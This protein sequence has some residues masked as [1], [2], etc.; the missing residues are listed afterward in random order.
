MN[1]ELSPAQK[2]KSELQLERATLISWLAGIDKELQEIDD[3]RALKIKQLRLLIEEYQLTPEELGL[4]GK[5]ALSDR[6]EKMIV[7]EN[8]NKAR[9]SRE[10]GQA[11][12]LSR[13]GG[14]RNGIPVIVD[15]LHY[16]SASAAARFL[17][18]NSAT[19]TNRCYNDKYPSY[20]FDETFHGIR[21]V[22]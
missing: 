21:K 7:R 4:G 14:G 22:A 12:R 18:V 15:G 17:K 2:R 13:D 9:M 19:V 11:R 5:V 16:E 20:Q 3:A 10:L 8:K 1:V 6:L